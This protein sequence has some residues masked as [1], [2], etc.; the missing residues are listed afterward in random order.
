MRKTRTFCLR[1]SR[2]DYKRIQDYA[3]QMPCQTMTQFIVESC[4]D[5]MLRKPKKILPPVL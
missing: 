3:R 5:T 1:L 4:I 2:A